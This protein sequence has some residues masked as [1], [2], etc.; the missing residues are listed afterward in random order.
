MLA[1]SHEVDVTAELPH[2]AA[3]TLVLH[4]ERDRAAPLAQGRALAG[5]IPGA[6]IEVLDGHTHLPYIGDAD[7]VVRASR[8]FLGLRV[9]RERRAVPLTP[10]LTEVAA[11]VAEGRTNREIARRL[12]ITERT[13]E[14]H[15]ERIRL[16]LGLRSRSQIAA[17]YV[18]SGR[19]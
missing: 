9:P 7:S 13:A 1:L 19:R 16:R 11:L 5:R 15:V 2:I 17:W 6:A 14:S 3:P 4:R 10:R 12:Q 8:R 18:S